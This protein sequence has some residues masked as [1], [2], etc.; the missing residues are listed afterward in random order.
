[1]CSRN[2]DAFYQYLKE[3]AYI[4][5]CMSSILLSE[6]KE[7]NVQITKP[8]QKYLRFYHLFLIMAYELIFISKK[9]NN[10]GK[11]TAENKTPLQH[12]KKN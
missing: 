8:V 10:T 4:I 7:F 12:N 1:M 9:Q 2:T 6:W 5:K 11:Y 3:W